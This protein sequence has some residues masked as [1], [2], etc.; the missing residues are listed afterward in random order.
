M[1]GYGFFVEKAP[2]YFK[3]DGGLLAA[4]YTKEEADGTVEKIEKIKETD[5]LMLW[6]VTFFSKPTKDA[7][8]MKASITFKSW[9]KCT[10][11]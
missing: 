2:P 6:T 3:V 9:A 4:A 8:K 7:P 11:P 1:T 10:K 5:K